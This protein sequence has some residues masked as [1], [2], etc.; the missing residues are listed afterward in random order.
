[1]Y[2]GEIV[3]LGETRQIFE[4]PQDERTRAYLQG[5]LQEPATVAAI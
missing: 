2:L 3:E 4:S 5:H 1:M